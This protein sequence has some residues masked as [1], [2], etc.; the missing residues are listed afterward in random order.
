MSDGVLIIGGGLAAQRCAEALRQG[1]Y[2]GPVRIVSAEPHAP[3]DRPPLSKELLAGDRE[4]EEITFRPDEW[5]EEKEIELVLGDPAVAL[6]PE[7]RLVTLES[8]AE[9]HYEDLVI[10]TGSR[11]VMLADAEG[12]EN[13]Q[14]LRTVDDALRLR[15][16]LQPGS[17]LGVVGAGLISQEVA[18]TAS[19]REVHVTLVEAEPLP[20]ARALHP[21]LALWLVEMQR[22]AGI[23]VRLDT[24]VTKIV[25]EGDRAVALEL[26]DGSRVE[27]DHVLV[28][29]GIRPA[30][31]W[32]PEGLETLL[33]RP[34]IHAAGD[35]A[36]GEHWEAAGR[37]GRAAAQEILGNPPAEEALSSWWTDI[38]GVRIQG[39]GNSN[40]ADEL[41]IDGDMDEPSFTV[42]ALRDGTPVGALA[43]ACPREVP[44]LREL[45]SGA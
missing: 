10:A 30:D 23:D 32:L 5:H 40:D 2:E 17:R 44:R 6:D 13:V 8:G 29:I 38:H 26:S 41:E 28:A 37:Q 11:P 16:A 43:V 45:L 15:D 31:E 33:E 4:H 35:V 25:A 36:G 9:L 21:D 24:A 3:Y 27:V 39:F 22:S 20:L 7:A 12:L 14:A 34:E 19:K 1:E 42:V 18:S